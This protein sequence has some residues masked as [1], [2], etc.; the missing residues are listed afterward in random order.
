MNPEHIMGKILSK[1]C[2]IDNLY[3]H[4]RKWLNNLV[5]NWSYNM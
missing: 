4:V 3:V 2:F 5:Q 1:A